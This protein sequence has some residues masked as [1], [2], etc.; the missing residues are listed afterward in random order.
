ME[1]SQQKP[2]PRRLSPTTSRPGTPSPPAPV[3]N[4]L[5]HKRLRSLQTDLKKESKNQLLSVPEPTSPPIQL[6]GSSAER[7]A[8][9]SA[10]N[11]MRSNDLAMARSRRLRPPKLNIKLREQRD[12]MMDTKEED[13]L[14]IEELLIEFCNSCAK[15]N[16]AKWIN[17]SDLSLYL[18]G[19]IPHFI[20][21]YNQP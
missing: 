17:V 11:S 8:T 12:L 5:Q 10:P 14:E 13:D 15:T 7:L 4:L 21:Q 6:T 16:N 1:Q 3:D 18:R 9:S 20:Q 19:Q 2:S